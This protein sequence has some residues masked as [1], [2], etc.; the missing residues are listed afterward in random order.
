MKKISTLLLLILSYVTFFAQETL[1]KESSN[2]EA[3]T[4]VEVMPEFPGGEDALVAFLVNNIKYP[5]EAT[6][7]DISG[8]VY[9]NFVVDKKGNCIKHKVT[10]SPSPILSKEALRIM[11]KMPKWKPGKQGGKPVSVLYDVPITFTLED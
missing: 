4:F 3:F 11:K 6:K 5:K 2:D 7:K 1:K 8:T 9:V 10:K